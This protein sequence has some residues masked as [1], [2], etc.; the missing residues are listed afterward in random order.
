MCTSISYK[1][2][3]SVSQTVAEMPITGEQAPTVM[4]WN[5]SSLES[6]LKIYGV[7]RSWSSSLTGKHISVKQITPN[8]PISNILS[9]VIHPLSVEFIVELLITESTDIFCSYVHAKHFLHPVSSWPSPNSFTLHLLHTS[10]YAML[11][12][13]A[14]TF[15]HLNLEQFTV[16]LH[17][18]SK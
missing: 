3:P 14:S 18:V 12:S 10:C 6:W 4:I 2:W 11:A 7:L 13:Y 9:L 8:H 15:E 16:Y 17:G 1:C 5:Q